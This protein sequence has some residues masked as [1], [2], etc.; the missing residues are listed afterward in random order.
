MR[1]PPVCFSS[2]PLTALSEDLLPLVVFVLQNEGEA[3][4]ARADERVL[5][6]IEDGHEGQI[7]VHGQELLADDHLAVEVHADQRRVVHGHG[8]TLAVWTPGDAVGPAFGLD[9][10]VLGHVEGLGEPEPT[11]PIMSLALAYFWMFLMSVFITVSTSSIELTAK[12]S[13]EG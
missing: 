12:I 2:A 1:N 5:V 10:L 6:G 4:V 8:Q 13:S 11:S 3:V 7:P 9:V